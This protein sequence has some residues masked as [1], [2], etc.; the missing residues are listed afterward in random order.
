VR[1]ARWKLIEFWREPRE[2]EL[3]DLQAD[4]QERN[5][6]AHDP[7]LAQTL[8]QLRTRLAELRARYDDRDPPDYLPEQQQ[9]QVCHYGG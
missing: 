8:A 3:Y 2:Y 7:A 4:P 9:L 5:N 1:N 6:L